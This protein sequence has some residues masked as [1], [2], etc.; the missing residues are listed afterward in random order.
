MSSQ[1]GQSVTLLGC[2]SVECR[3]ISW[4]FAYSIIFV[5]AYVFTYAIAFLWR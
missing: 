4:T 5:T 3:A 1:S 2:I